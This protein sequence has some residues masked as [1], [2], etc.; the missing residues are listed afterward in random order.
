MYWV[1]KTTA[2]LTMNFLKAQVH[3]PHDVERRNSTIAL[4][5]ERE[6]SSQPIERQRGKM[7]GPAARVRGHEG[8]RPILVSLIP[9]PAV[10]R[11]ADLSS[12]SGDPCHGSPH[13]ASFRMVL[14]HIV[15]KA[16]VPKIK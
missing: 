12:C 10:V 14:S 11:Q 9:G 1:Q 2:V 15:S 7:M 4:A 16:P 6:R 8:H 3:K 5:A 13:G